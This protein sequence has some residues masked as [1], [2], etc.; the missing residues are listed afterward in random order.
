MNGA[1]GGM[2]MG[3]SLYN[4]YNSNSGPVASYSNTGPGDPMWGMD[5][6]FG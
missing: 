6:G 2:M 1:M 4:N 5:L 3:N